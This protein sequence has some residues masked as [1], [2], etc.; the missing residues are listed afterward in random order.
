MLSSIRFHTVSLEIHVNNEA[1]IES[2]L[3]ELRVPQLGDRSWSMTSIKT[4]CQPCFAWN[5]NGSLAC[6]WTSNTAP[7]MTTTMISPESLTV[8]RTVTKLRI[9]PNF[10]FNC[11]EVSGLASIYSLVPSMIGKLATLMTTV[12]PTSNLLRIAGS[13]AFCGYAQNC[14]R[15]G[16]RLTS[17]TGMPHQSV[18][19]IRKTSEYAAYA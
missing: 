3:L 10:L 14:C 9:H 2:L 6:H 18:R 16:T 5:V 4:T 17:N 15:K 11:G 7:P 8:P 19:R 13:F 12:S 1:A